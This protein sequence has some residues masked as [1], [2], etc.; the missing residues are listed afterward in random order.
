MKPKMY[1]VE[2][3][4]LERQMRLKIE[5]FTFALVHH[6][7]STFKGLL[8]FTNLAFGLFA[9]FLHSLSLKYERA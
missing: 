6:P 7:L 9:S 5:P 8:S 2:I 1:N 4:V 3:K